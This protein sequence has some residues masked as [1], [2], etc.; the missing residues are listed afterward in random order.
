M[1]Q[2]LLAVIGCQCFIILVEVG[3]T[4]RPDK[5]YQRIASS[6]VLM[7]AVI[8]A[9]LWPSGSG[10]ALALLWLA[11]VIIP[12]FFQMQ[13]NVAVRK[14]DSAGISRA[15]RWL[16][17]LTP[18]VGW[19]E[20]EAYYL[21]QAAVSQGRWNDARSIIEAARSLPGKF[22]DQAQLQGLLWQRDWEQLLIATKRVAAAEDDQLIYGSLRVRALAEVG[23][24]DECLAALGELSRVQRPRDLSSVYLAVLALAGQVEPVRRLLASSALAASP[25]HGY[26][27]GV[28]LLAAGDAEQGVLTLEQASRAGDSLFGEQARWR[29]ETTRPPGL[30]PS[31]Q[32]RLRQLIVAWP[33]LAGPAATAA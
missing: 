26:W 16:H 32:D 11:L 5:G 13:L 31:A 1:S 14:A 25:V 12:G 24:W 4:R 3:K 30:S 8:G 21:S 15:I 22:K 7:A 27:L 23:R 28:A 17:R 29:R 18:W 2:F 20:V 10:Y 6:A 9:V 19:R 33:L